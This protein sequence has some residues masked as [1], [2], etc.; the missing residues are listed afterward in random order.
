MVFIE[1]KFSW[2]EYR[3]CLGIW[4]HNLGVVT[5]RFAH[6]SLQFSNFTHNLSSAMDPII[7]HLASQKIPPPNRC[8]RGWSFT[9]DYTDFQETLKIIGSWKL[10][11]F[12]RCSFCKS[13]FTICLGIFLCVSLYR[14]IQTDHWSSLQITNLNCNHF[15]LVISKLA[16]IKKFPYWDLMIG[17]NYCKFLVLMV[18]FQLFF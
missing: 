2:K 8:H 15:S 12:C 18:V 16:K 4:V 13:D 1:D 11:I 5:M 10:Q 14:W 3:N 9:E 17:R 7:Y 6:F